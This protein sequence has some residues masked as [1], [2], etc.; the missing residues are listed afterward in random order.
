MSRFFSF[1]LLVFFAFFGLT[2]FQICKAA[3][4]NPYLVEGVMVNVTDKS[5][6]AARNL[7]VAT[8]RRDAFL[9]L[10]TR[11]EEKVAIADYISDDEIAYMVGS[12]QI[13]AERI[14]GNNYSAT[15]NIFFAKNFVKHVLAQK[16][17]MKNLA[18]IQESYLLVP[19]KVSKNKNITLWE[20]NDWRQVIAKSLNKKSQ[21]LDKR[22]FIIPD[23][24]VENLAILSRENIQTIDYKTLE[25]MLSKYGVGA[26]YILILSFDEIENKASIEVTRLQKLQ[27]KQTK[28]NFIN[29]DRLSY[30][31]LLDKVGLKTIEYLISSLNEEQKALSSNLVKI[32]IPLNSLGEWLML[33]NKIESSNLVNQLNIESIS[34]DLAVI[35]VNYIGFEDIALAFDKIGLRIEKKSENF[36]RLLVN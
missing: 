17:S 27:K 36:Y 18:E 33:K 29:V 30:G 25:P 22:K 2:T 11:L 14:A 13:D 7:A 8:A 21:D 3:D 10:L 5:P 12:E 15:F 19:A 6:S 31:T 32:E 23:A 4:Q 9:V 26:A 20:K 16:S 34:R 35:T 1:F 24:D 28:L